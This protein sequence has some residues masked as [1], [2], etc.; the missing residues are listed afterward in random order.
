MPHRRLLLAAPLA[1]SACASLL[2]AQKYTPRVSWP[3]Q[4][5]PPAGVASA[6]GAP[7]L[8]VRPISAAPGLEARGLQSLAADGSLRVDYYNLWAVPPADAVTQALLGWSEASG[9]FSAVITP[10][11]RLQPG[12]IVE[13]ELTELLADPAHGEARAALTLVVIKPGAG[14]VAVPLRQALLRAAVPLSADDPAARVQAQSQAL[15][16]VLAQVM[17]LLRLYAN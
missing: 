17:A 13:G 11:S 3:L 15:S 2:P 5:Q 9:A 4:P 10:G 1:L 7:V 16:G 12:L 14:G 8:L 6:P